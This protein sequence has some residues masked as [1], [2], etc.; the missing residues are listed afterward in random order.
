MGINV[1]KILG[2]RGS[3]PVSGAAFARYGGATT[4][5]FVRLA[6]QPFVLD[7][8]SG[9]LALPSVL[10]PEEKQLTLLLTHPHADHLLGLPMCKT[11]FEPD[12]KI[13]FYASVRGTLHAE[14]QLQRLMTPPLWPVDPA[15]LP[16]D[17]CFH[18]LPEEMQLGAV[19][20]RSMEGIHPG[21]V[22][23]LRLDGDGK[24]IVLATDCSLTESL[25][26][27]AVEFARNC[28]LLLCDGQYQ[29]SEWA[30]KSTFGH[31]TWTSAAAFGRLCGAKQTRI[32]HH[33]PTR[34]DDELDAATEELGAGCT[35]AYE[36]HEFLASVRNA[37][38][39]A[40][41]DALNMLNAHRIESK[42]E[43]L[44]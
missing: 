18:D 39:R 7:A 23:L 9:M 27:K 24:S 35:F 38:Q 30:A 16:A 41:E 28:D 13:D 37:D 3:V 5:F 25:L 42:K 33:N 2:V 21:G 6:G 12:R 15:D 43:D 1:V 29:E 32:I 44:T 26:P 40:R 20:V 14:A 4:C 17:I 11:V 8:G 34:T 31:N 36:G 10:Q 19:R 22:S